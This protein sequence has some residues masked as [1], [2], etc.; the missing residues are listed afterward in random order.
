VLAYIR[1]ITKA[2]ISKPGT[3]ATEHT[4]SVEAVA[5]SPTL[6]AAVTAS[7]DGTMMVWDNST[8]ALRATCQHSEVPCR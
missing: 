7:M 1:S 4:D 5:F 6:P 3:C 2:S 8:L